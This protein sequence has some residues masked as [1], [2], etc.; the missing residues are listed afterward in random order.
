MPNEIFDDFKNNIEKTQHI[1][2]SYA[3]YYF[4]SHL[5]RHCEYEGVTQAIIKERLG[6]NQNEK[7]LDYLIKKD[8]VLD[9]IGYTETTKDFPIGWSLDEDGTVCFNTIQELDSSLIP[10]IS[11]KNFKV[12]CPLKFFYRTRE[13]QH[14]K[15]LDGI[16]YDISSTHRI[17]YKDFQTCMDNKELGTMAFFIYAWISHKNDIY[18]GAYTRPSRELSAEL[19]ISEPTL[20]K[21]LDN[22]QKHKL[23]NIKHEKFTGKGGDANS[24]TAIRNRTKTKK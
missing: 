21:Y 6:Y 8:G 12:K 15:V 13:A 4:I 23:L 20:F 5:Y 10:I 17:F 18:Q 9:S 16:L 2:F 1:A 3:Y 22:M 11:E 14:E 24:Y 19:G 7:R